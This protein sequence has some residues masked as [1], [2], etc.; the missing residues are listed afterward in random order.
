MQ[1][2]VKNTIYKNVEEN[3]LDLIRIS[4]YIHENPELGYKEFKAVEKLTSYLKEK[5]NEVIIPF[6]G[7]DTSFSASFTQGKGERHIAV[8]AE[9]DALPKLGHAC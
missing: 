1:S 4:E 9:Y 2:D 7:L 5:G 8:L 6:G 3:K